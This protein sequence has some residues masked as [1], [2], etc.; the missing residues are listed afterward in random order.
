MNKF[1]CDRND[2]Y[3][4]ENGICI[5]DEHKFDLYGECE[6]YFDEYMAEELHRDWNAECIDIDDE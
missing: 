6:N 1:M 3:S 4:N 5:N 2:C